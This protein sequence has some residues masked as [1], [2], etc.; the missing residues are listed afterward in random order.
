MLSMNHTYPPVSQTSTKRSISKLPLSSTTDVS[1]SLLVVGPSRPQFFFFGDR[2][3]I[4]SIGTTSAVGNIFCDD[5][6]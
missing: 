3:L 2:F 1:E 4:L 6:V 5:E